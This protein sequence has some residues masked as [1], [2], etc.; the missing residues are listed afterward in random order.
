MWLNHKCVSFSTS[1]F[2]YSGSGSIFSTQHS[3]S[4]IHCLRN[5]SHHHR[6]GCNIRYCRCS[7]HSSLAQLLGQPN[8]HLYL[9]SYLLRDQSNL[10]MRKTKS[11]HFMFFFILIDKYSTKDKFVVLPGF[12]YC[13]GMPIYVG[14]PEI[15]R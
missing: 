6:F 7:M 5:N 10:I 11:I 2:F 14:L 8:H 9:G 15:I 3:Q 12:S 13:T 1:T 4:C